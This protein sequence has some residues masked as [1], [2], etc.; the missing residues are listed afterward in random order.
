MIASCA[1]AAAQGGGAGGFPDFESE[2]GV[3]WEPVLPTAPSGLASTSVNNLTELNSAMAL[4]GREITLNSGT[5]YGTVNLAG[6]NNLL[7]VSDNVTIDVL[8]TSSG[9]DTVTMRF[10]T[11]RDV[12]SVV[13]YIE[14]GNTFEHSVTDILLDGL[15][16][17]NTPSSGQSNRL[18]ADN[19]A[20]IN[21]H[22]IAGAYG[23][24]TDKGVGGY[25]TNFTLWNNIIV[26]GTY[27]PNAQSL[28]RVTGQ[29]R[30]IVCGNR[31][32]Q[33]NGG[34]LT[35]FYTLSDVWCSHNQIE[36]PDG[37]S[38]CILGIYSS[39]GPPVLQTVGL[40]FRSN[41][42]YNASSGPGAQFEY[43]GG[44]SSCECHDNA[45]YTDSGSAAWPVT[46][47]GLTASGNTKVAYQSPPA[48]SF[49]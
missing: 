8:G 32:V 34:L 43:S 40:N 44:G 11:P 41:A 13:K 48:W 20:I 29:E 19:S 36:A 16:V 24:Y 21:S 31:L 26:G 37:S 38:G 10:L 45:A 18:H 46:Q 39:T 17:D 3:P 2:F 14:N 9:V 12:T 23:L 22:M 7:L 27:V 33:Y 25:P 6:T 49:A 5:S 15:R 28:L 35:R 4:G 47:T 1:P 42:V 30:L